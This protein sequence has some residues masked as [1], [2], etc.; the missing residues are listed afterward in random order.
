MHGS[1]RRTHSVDL[2]TVCQH[3]HLHEHAARYDD[4][5][6]TVI[7]NDMIPRRTVRCRLSDP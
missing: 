1:K 3:P 7:V 4:D 5:V 6:I 2:T